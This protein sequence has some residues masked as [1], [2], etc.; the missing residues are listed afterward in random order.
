MKSHAPNGRRALGP[1]IAYP[2]GGPPSGPTSR[3]RCRFARTSDEGTDGRGDL[4]RLLHTRLRLASL[5]T[6]APFLFFLAKKFFEPVVCDP[7]SPNFL[8]QAGVTAARALPDRLRLAAADA[9]LGR[10]ADD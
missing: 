3:P 10:T 4:R 1:T 6:T 8:I 7:S 5:I 9:G 2:A